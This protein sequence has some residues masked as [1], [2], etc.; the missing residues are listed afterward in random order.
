VGEHEHTFFEQSHPPNITPSDFRADLVVSPIPHHMYFVPQPPSSYSDQ[1]PDD[2]VLCSSIPE[3]TLFLNE[4]RSINGVGVSQPT[5]D[6]IQE[7]CDCEFEHPPTVEDHPYL[8]VP[9]PFSPDILDDP[10]IPN[11]SCVSSSTDE[12]IVDHSRDT[13]YVIPSSDNREYQSFI[14]NPLDLSFVFSKNAE[15]EYY[16]FSSTPLCDSS[17]HEDVDQHP[18]FSD[19]VYR[20]LFTSS[21]IQDVDSL[22]VN[23]S[24]PLVYNDPFVNE[25]ETPQTLEVL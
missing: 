25:F 22:I 15:D 23:L 2:T 4:D 19:L 17:Y 18:E 12:P 9:P 5:C 3:S 1:P 24:K 6:A 7:E 10:T 20:D 14:E 11:S 13:P 16:C 8:S 21:S